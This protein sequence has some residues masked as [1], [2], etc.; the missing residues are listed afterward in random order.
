[1]AITAK[2][3]KRMTFKQQAKYIATVL[4]KIEYDD[5]GQPTNLFF[6]KYSS[7][8][9][10]QTKRPIWAWKIYFYYIKPKQEYVPYEKVKAEWRGKGIKSK[11][12]GIIHTIIAIDT[13]SDICVLVDG[14]WFRLEH[15]FKH[16]TW[17]NGSPFGELHDATDRI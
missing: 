3:F 17:E 16:Y 12:N 10:L 13:N 1:M 2:L 4:D 6:H 8:E 5:K 9:E 14:S 11:V 7:S 15:L